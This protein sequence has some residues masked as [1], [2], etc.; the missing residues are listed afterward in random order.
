[1]CILIYVFVLYLYIYIYIVKYYYIYSEE[2]VI[3]QYLINI[4]PEFKKYCR[5]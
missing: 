3:D 5:V 1:M 4:P 2:F